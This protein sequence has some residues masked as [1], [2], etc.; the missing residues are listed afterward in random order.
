MLRLG[1]GHPAGWQACSLAWPGMHLHLHL[2]LHS[3]LH[4]HA[5]ATLGRCAED[6][7]NQ[8]MLDYRS[9]AAPLPA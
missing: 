8:C 6:H 4:L 9:L 3:H 7:R 5:Y 2:H 1:E